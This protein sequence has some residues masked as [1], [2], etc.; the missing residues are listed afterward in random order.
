[1]RGFIGILFFSLLL[2]SCKTGQTKAI[3]D[4]DRLEHLTDVNL[5][6]KADAWEIMDSHLALKPD[7]ETLHIIGN[8]EYSGMGMSVQSDI[9]IEKGKQILVI[10][11]KFGF[12]GAKIL[13]TPERV[14]YYESVNNSYYDGDFSLLNQLFGVA[15]DYEKVENLL[16]GKALY[17]SK[18]E[19]KDQA[20][21]DGFY[22]VIAELLTA[23]QFIEFQ[24]WID[25]GWHL[26]KEK[27][28]L[29]GSPIELTINYNDYKQNSG[30]VLP[31]IVHLSATNLHE[32]ISLKLNYTKV[33][34][35]TE[36][37]FTYEI[38]KNAKEIVL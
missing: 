14:S 5:N 34:K 27:M 32:E 22:R 36:L 11:R 28:L 4:S 2:V 29:K 17:D 38:P 21:E 12:T 35:D 3:K 1:M 16:L 25:G 30:I 23:H 9:R 19:I 7:F 10:I 18:L 15:F 13:I 6:E 31:H 8:A 33:N 37:N 26:Q 24:Y 20:I